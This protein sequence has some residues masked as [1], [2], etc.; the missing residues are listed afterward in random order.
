MKVGDYIEVKT[1]SEIFKGV[2]MPDSVNGK[3]VLKLDNGYNI[4]IEK[5]RIK[6]K[7][8][9]KKAGKKRIKTKKVK[10][11]SNL[12]RILILHFGG[13]IASKVDYETGGVV[14]KFKPDEI[15]EMFPEIKDIANIES[16]MIGNILSENIRFSHYNILAREIK[17][18]IEE[19]FDGVIVTHGTDTMHYTSAAL[20]F[21][22]EGLGVPVLLVGA[23][24]SSDRGSSDAALNLICACQFIAK[25]DFGDVGIC[26][27]KSSDDISC[28]VLNGL[29]TKKMHTSRRDAFRPI[30]IEPWAEVFPDGRVIYYRRDYRKK[31]KNKK[32]DLRLIKENLK[33]GILKV[34]P[35]M[36]A[37]E[38]KKYDNFDG[39]V[40]EGTG[41][42]H[43]PIEKI[44]RFSSENEKIFKALKGLKIP[45]VMCSQTVYGRVNMNVYSTGRMIQRY[46]I[47]GED[48]T[49][50]TAFIKL[51]WVLSNYPKEVKKKM[52]EDIRGEINKKISW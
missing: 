37:E 35:N 8:I 39:L 27:H 2:L 34:H 25:S 42:G 43:I 17:E 41:L 4:G 40:I 29:K 5:K 23:Q 20:S 14:A 15:I 28:Y 16:K 50:E 31:E 48:M 24:R 6:E 32:V 36:F 13:T 7:K 46:L 51:A 44:D 38:I 11:K 22:L 33:I 12:P 10:Q 9:I 45:K 47:N 30:N 19:G 18:G 26:M 49:S 52:E 1:D 21:I 3:L